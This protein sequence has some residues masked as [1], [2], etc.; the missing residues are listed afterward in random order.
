MQAMKKMD[1]LDQTAR[2]GLPDDV[3]KT[4]P[5]APFWRPELAPLP[6]HVVEALA[7]G[8]VAPPLIPGVESA[9]LLLTPD[10]LPLDTGFTVGD[11]GSITVAC[12]TDMPDVTPPMWDWWM[13][14]H[15]SA[16]LRYRLWHPQA[17]SRAWYADGYQNEEIERDDWRAHIGYAEEYIGS[18]FLS[19]RLRFMQPEA[20]GYDAEML[21]KRDRYTLLSGRGGPAKLPFYFGCLVHAIR[22]VPGGSEMHSR[23]WFGGPQIVPIEKSG[24]RGAAITKV[25]GSRVKLTDK[26]ARDTLVHCAEEMNHLTPIL[27]SLYAAFGEGW[28]RRTESPC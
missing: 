17:H 4:S 9:S 8:P 21:S 1:V 5:L 6:T 2:L 13:A 20:L 11:D 28:R 19:L 23:F 18:S 24:L 25:L 16:P 12:R 22:A 14:W 10:N 26:F 7:R 27:P 15:Q 3:L